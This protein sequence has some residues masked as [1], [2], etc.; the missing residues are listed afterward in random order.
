[1]KNPFVK[2]ERVSPR[3]LFTG[4]LLAAVG[5]LAACC[6]LQYWQLTERTVPAQGRLTRPA[7]ELSVQE[8]LAAAGLELEDVL[9]AYREAVAEQYRFF[10]FGDAMFIAGGINKNQ[11]KPVSLCRPQQAEPATS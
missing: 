11:E 9:A 8:Q 7:V 6:V 1:M 10:S 3:S 2:G 5:V 4:V